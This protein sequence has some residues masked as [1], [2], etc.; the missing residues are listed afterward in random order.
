LLSEECQYRA[1]KYLNNCIEQD[2]RYIKRRVEPDLGFTS[3]QTAWRTLQGYEAMNMIRKEQVNT[4][5]KHNIQAQN[6]FIPQ[7]FALSA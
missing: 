6:R 2:H 4:A 5:E 1:S 7:L 3:Y